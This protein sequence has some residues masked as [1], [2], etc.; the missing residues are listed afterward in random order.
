MV[1][2]T[3]FIEDTLKF[4]RDD[5]DT[6]ITDP[7]SGSRANRE[8]FVMSHYPARAVKY[9]VI[10]ITQVGLS[11]PQRGGL[12]S[13]IDIYTITIEIRIWA[14][15]VTEVVQLTDE[16]MNQLR[17]NQFG[18]AEASTS[19]NLHDW[20]IESLVNV[21]VPQDDNR[22]LRT[23]VIEISYLFVAGE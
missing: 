3:T 16:V 2:T 15:S 6:N 19:S 21:D 8:R 17:L 13:E 4:I 12:Q 20:K 5:L 7:I 10:T 22:Y 9:P 18:G 1:S 11:H 23:K 14:R